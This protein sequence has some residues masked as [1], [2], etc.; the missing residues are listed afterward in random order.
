ML[1]WT[2]ICHNTCTYLGCIVS[3]LSDLWMNT[4]LFTRT[5]NANLK[6]DTQSNSQ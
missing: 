3:L 4:Q 6:A 5:D 2:F 1:L